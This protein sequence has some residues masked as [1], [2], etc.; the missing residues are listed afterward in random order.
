MAS[1][2]PLDHPP[3][4]RHQTSQR[5][6]VVIPGGGLAGLTL[7]LQ[8]KRVRPQTSIPVAEK[9]AEPAPEATF[10]VGESTVEI[11]AYYYSHVVGLQDTS[12]PSTT[13][14]SGC[15]SSCRRGQ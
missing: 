9:H 8:L 13:A 4:R 1:T 11:G 15:G 2:G 5:H 3:D 7:A 12:M 6:D 14:S 10:K